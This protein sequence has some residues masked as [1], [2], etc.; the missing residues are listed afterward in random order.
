MDVL[1][2]PA[3]SPDVN[4]IEPGKFIKMESNTIMLATLLMLLC[5]VG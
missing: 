3:K 1:P 5:L 4:I 2:W